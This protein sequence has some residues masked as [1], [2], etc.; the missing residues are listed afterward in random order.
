MEALREEITRMNDFSGEKVVL[1]EAG[2]GETKAEDKDRAL[3]GGQTAGPS[4]M[5]DKLTINANREE[6]GDGRAEIFDMGLIDQ[7]GN[8]TNLLLKGEMFTIKEKSGLTRRYRLL[9]L[10]TQLRIRRAAI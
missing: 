2:S 6:Y 10:R 7:R 5:R 9:S 8:I 4:L 3:A 1:A